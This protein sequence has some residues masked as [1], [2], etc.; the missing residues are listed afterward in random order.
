MS[1]ERGTPVQETQRLGQAGECFGKCQALR[2]ELQ[3]AP[4]AAD[5]MKRQPP[6]SPSRSLSP[7]LP[8][9]RPAKG[10]AAQGPRPIKTVTLLAGPLRLWLAGAD[11]SS[12][13]RMWTS[14]MGRA[15]TN[16]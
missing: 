13:R 6:L 14:A 16:L 1:Y 3:D 10:Q 11:R 8:N 2:E 12:L 5:A 7:R 15:I 9:P 4:G